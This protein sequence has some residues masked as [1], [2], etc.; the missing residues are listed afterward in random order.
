MILSLASRQKRLYYAFAY[1]KDYQIMSIII[2]PRHV[3]IIDNDYF[4][5]IVEQKD[6]IITI[7][8][9]GRTIFRGDLLQLQRKKPKSGIRMTTADFEIIGIDGTGKGADMNFRVHLKPIMIQP[10]LF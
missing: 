2:A 9:A 6:P 1:R 3:Q 8:A 5:W 4:D 10:R 7:P